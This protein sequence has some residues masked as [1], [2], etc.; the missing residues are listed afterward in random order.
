MPMRRSATKPTSRLK[1]IEAATPMA[2]AS[3]KLVTAPLTSR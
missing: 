1:T 3:A 2:M